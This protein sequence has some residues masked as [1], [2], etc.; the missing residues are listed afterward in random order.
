MASARRSMLEV[1]ALNV[2]SAGAM[3]WKEVTKDLKMSTAVVS[4]ITPHDLLDFYHH[5]SGSIDSPAP[6]LL[7]SSPKCQKHHPLAC[8]PSSAITLSL[9]NTHQVN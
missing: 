9:K 7:T 3:T 2:W 4:D 1:Q 5:L 6:P 8:L